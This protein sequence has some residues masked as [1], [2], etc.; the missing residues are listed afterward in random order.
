MEALC[1]NDNSK[2]SAEFKELMASDFTRLREKYGIEKEYR[3]SLEKISAGKITGGRSGSFFFFTEDQR[4]AI[5]TMD[6]K[7]QKVLRSLMKASGPGGFSLRSVMSSGSDLGA[8]VTPI[9]SS[10]SG[11]RVP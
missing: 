7:E 6:E 3:E 11:A 9:A 5:K 10:S 2:E 4:F 8:M 1:E